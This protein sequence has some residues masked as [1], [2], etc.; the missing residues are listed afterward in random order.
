MSTHGFRPLALAALAGTQLMV[1]LDGTIVTVALPTIRSGLGFSDASLSGVVNA[2]FVAF[3]LVLLPAGR[4]GDVLGKRDVFLAG[5]GLFTV[6]SAACAIAWDP[7]SLLVARAAQ[8]V[9]GGLTSAVVLAMVAALY[10]DAALRTRA[11]ALLAFIGSAGASIGLVSG[12]VLTEFA[13]WR[14]VFGVNVPIGLAILVLAVRV[15]ARQPGSGVAG[16]LVPRA[17]FADPRFAVANGVLF[18]MVM[19]GMSFQFLSSL[20][21]QDTLGHG[22][23]ATGLAF[24]AVSGAIAVSSLGLSGR[25]AARY[26]AAR[27]LV[28]GLL[29]F[30]A[31]M[32][33]MVRLP[34]DGGYLLDVAPGFV[35]MGLG[36]GLAMPQAI[37]IAMGAAPVE[38]SGVA[39]GFA[40]TAQQAGGALGLFAVAAAAAEAGRGVGYGLAVLALVVAT[41]LAAYLAP[42]LA[43]GGC[44]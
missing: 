42:A 23:L 3:A 15:L 21:L 27:V 1:I 4:V 9:G 12:G 6:A 36:F 25:L 34:D 11:F 30:T 16:G 20:Y 35:I 14:W 10:D 37:E 13:S 41:V 22:P 7:A 26:G 29:L 40:N 43:H 19:A 24:L 39:S 18:A 32:L 2:F 31:G 5:L 17:L 8:G 33:M 28:A 38:H 44:G